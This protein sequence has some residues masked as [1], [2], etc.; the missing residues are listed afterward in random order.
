MC[1]GMREMSSMVPKSAILGLKVKTL[2]KRIPSWYQEWRNSVRSEVFCGSEA[3]K[4]HQ[5]PPFA[6]SKELQKV[7][8]TI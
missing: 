8:R 6:T 7:Q 5:Q 2:C 4:Q 3:S 1:D